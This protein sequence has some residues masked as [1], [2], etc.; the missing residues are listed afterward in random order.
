MHAIHMEGTRNV[1][2]ALPPGTRLVH[3]SSVVTVGASRTGAVLC[4]RSRFNLASLRVDYV[5]AKRR[6]EQRVFAAAESGA[7]VVVVNPAYMIGPDDYERSAMGR[8]CVRFWRRRV[9]L[10]PPGGFNVVDVRD[11]AAGHLLAAEHGTRGERYILGGE[12]L[13]MLALAARLARARGVEMPRLRQIPGWAQFLAACL[14][15]ARSAVVRREAYPSFQ[16]TRLSR[17]FWYFDSSH[18]LRSLGFA[19]RPLD[20]TIAATHGWCVAEGLLAPLEGP[21]QFPAVVESRRVA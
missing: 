17:L 10:I 7:D 11:V 21:A 8:F 18:A 15:E 2:S 20:D 16:Q 6:S 9:P 14:A 1:L 12:N 4:E 19:A 13:S 5:H 3:T